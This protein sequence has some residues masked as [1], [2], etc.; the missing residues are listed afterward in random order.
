MGHLVRFLLGARG[1]IISTHKDSIVTLLEAVSLRK[2]DAKNDRKIRR[3]K[4][5]SL[6]F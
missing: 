4:E 5:M 3:E 1:S 6:S 2:S